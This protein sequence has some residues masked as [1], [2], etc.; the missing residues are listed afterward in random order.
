MVP[1]NADLVHYPYF[2]PFFPTLPLL[3]PKPV[4]VT[5]HDLIPL[6]FPDKFPAGLRGLLKWQLQRLSLLGADRIIADSAQSA[7]DIARYSGVSHER[8]DVVHLAP[9]ERFRKMDKKDK[10]NQRGIERVKAKHH[11][12]EH[13]ILYVGDVNWNKNIHGMLEAFRNLKTQNSK[14]KTKLVFVGAA[15]KNSLLAETKDI[16]NHIHSLNVTDDVMKLGF[17]PDEDLP[18]IYSLASVYIQP[19]F[20]EGFGLPVLEAMACGCPVVCSYVASL[21]EIGGP[22]ISI[23]PDDPANIASGILRVL[24]LSKEQRNKLIG[25]QRQW[26][27]QFTW[28]N[29]A[30]LTMK[31]YEKVLANK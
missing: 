2:D 21:R 31:A 22:A 4:A 29:V 20:Y 11:L 8:I 9:G 10:M 30:A 1:K 18:A 26:A 16:D 14:L 13:F 12:P 6:V 7:Q 15:F 3:K 27:K 28:R 25:D 17:V 23:D 5:V 19:S 24:S